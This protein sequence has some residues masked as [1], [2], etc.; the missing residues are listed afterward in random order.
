MRDIKR[1]PIGYGIELIKVGILV[2]EKEP[3]AIEKVTSELQGLS[4]VQEV[5]QEAMTLL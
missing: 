3:G 2:N 1:V 5:E 4:T